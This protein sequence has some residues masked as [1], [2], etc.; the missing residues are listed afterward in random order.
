M[1]KLYVIY[2]LKSCTVC[3]FSILSTKF[4]HSINAWVFE[5]TFSTLW[6]QCFL[7]ET[8]DTGLTGPYA[9]P[10]SGLSVEPGSALP[11]VINKRTEAGCVVFGNLIL[12]AAPPMYRPFLALDE[13]E[14][15]KAAKKKSSTIHL[16]PK[17]S[18]DG[19][20]LEGCIYIS[21]CMNVMSSLHLC[22]SDDP[23]AAK[24]KLLDDKFSRPGEIFCLCIFCVMN[25][26]CTGVQ[27]DWWSLGLCFKAM[28]LWFFMVLWCYYSLDLCITTEGSTMADV[29]R[30]CM[31]LS[32]QKTRIIC[33]LS[34]VYSVLHLLC[35]S[36]ASL[37]TSCDYELSIATFPTLF[38]WN[39][40]SLC[41]AFPYLFFYES[42]ISCVRQPSISLREQQ[43]SALFSACTTMYSLVSLNTLHQP[44][45]IALEF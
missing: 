26:V 15:Q 9:A 40:F 17:K 2:P 7:A 11:P 28:I 29:G 23:K 34:M 13:E 27:G 36:C 16:D 42:K 30:L 22:T 5:S 41:S 44:I 12:P 1:K 32:E 24:K 21:S 14:K 45:Q 4:Q 39:V 31:H 25:T 10:A 37:I 43:W 35:C 18:K 8:D 33:Q 20:T 6:S 38:Q 19:K 3:S